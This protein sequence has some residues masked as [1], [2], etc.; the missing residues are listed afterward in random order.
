M[1]TSCQQVF[2]ERLIETFN[3]PNRSKGEKYSQNKLGNVIVGE[4]SFDELDDEVRR[5]CHAI[6]MKAV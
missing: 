1:H 6:L 4:V 2:P 3:W 5:N